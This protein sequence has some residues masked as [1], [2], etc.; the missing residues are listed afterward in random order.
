[1][2][3]FPPFGLVFGVA[4]CGFQ[5]ATALGPSLYGLLHDTYGSY[6][7]ALIGAAV[8]DVAAAAVAIA[9]RCKPDAL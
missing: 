7:P 6:N 3:A 4:S 8:F 9:G 5:L 2:S 1:M